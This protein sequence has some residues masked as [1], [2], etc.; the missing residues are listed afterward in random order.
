MRLT[1]AR[2]D[3]F[4]EAHPNACFLDD[5][6]RILYVAE[7]REGF[8]NIF[9]CARGCY[10]IECVSFGIIE[11]EAKLYTSTYDL[12]DTYRETGCDA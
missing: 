10:V 2:I 8:F 5:D 1:P 11:I 12:L 4:L 9:E 6:G 3:A 7:L